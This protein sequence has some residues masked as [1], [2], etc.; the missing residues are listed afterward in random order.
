MPTFN[1]SNITSG[2]GE[3]QHNG[4]NFGSRTYVNGRLVSVDD[5]P[6]DGGSSDNY[7]DAGSSG[8]QNHTTHY[9]NITSGSHSSQHNGNNYSGT[10]WSGY[11]P[12]FGHHTTTYSN[13]T[14]GAG[15][16]QI[17]GDTYGVVTNNTGFVFSRT[18]DDQARAASSSD[19]PTGPAAQTPRPQPQPQPA[20]SAVPPAS[21]SRPELSPST[22]TPKASQE[23]AAKTQSPALAAFQK[24]EVKCEICSKGMPRSDKA[25]A[26]HIERCKAAQA[27]L[28]KT[29][30]KSPTSKDKQGKVQSGRVEKAKKSTLAKKVKKSPS[31]DS[32][33][34]LNDFL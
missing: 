32:D 3:T 28:K 8:F 5:Q 19:R 4:R 1:Y 17:F 23:T 12:G 27:E 9:S 11:I 7:T 25:Q 21:V 13:V 14:V 33:D 31:V 15:G 30:S 22:S 10:S 26:R 24:P 2:A 29:P 20:S 34:D 16:R 6:T 18:P